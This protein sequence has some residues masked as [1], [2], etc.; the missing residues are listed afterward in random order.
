LLFL[1]FFT[2]DKVIKLFFTGHRPELSGDELI[3]VRTN[4]QHAV[5]FSNHWTQQQST[6]ICANWRHISCDSNS[7]KVPHGFAQN[8][9]RE[10]VH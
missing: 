4:F 1:L 8:K 7:P 5:S 2:G 9:Q 6:K 10:T 3:K